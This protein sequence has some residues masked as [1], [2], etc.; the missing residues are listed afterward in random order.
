[1]PEVILFVF[2]EFLSRDLKKAAPGPGNEQ[3]QARELSDA[4]A[5]QLITCFLKGTVSAKAVVQQ[6]TN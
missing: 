1:M 2:G 5:W 4:F 6:E 3:R